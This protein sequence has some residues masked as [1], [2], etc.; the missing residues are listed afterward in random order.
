MNRTSKCSEFVD[1]L[2]FSESIYLIIGYQNQNGI[3]MIRSATGIN[4]VED[5]VKN[6][7]IIRMMC[8]YI[9]IWI[10]QPSADQ[11]HQHQVYP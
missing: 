7:V 11:F 9:I 8:S 10:N 4:I 3:N 6:F 1:L 5:A 2:H